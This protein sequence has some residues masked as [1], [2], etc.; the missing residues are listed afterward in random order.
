MVGDSRREHTQ[1]L[2]YNRF[3]EKLRVTSLMLWLDEIFQVFWYGRVV[4]Q[5]ALFP[6]K[7]DAGVREIGAN[8]AI[9]VGRNAAWKR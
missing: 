2:P 1:E 7:C 5:I 9:L 4:A 8:R 3:V 6:L